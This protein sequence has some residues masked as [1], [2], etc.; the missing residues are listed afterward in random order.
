MSRSYDDKGRLAYI[1]CDSCDA[2]IRPSSGIDSSEW[3]KTGTGNP[4]YGTYQQDWCP[5]CWDKRQKT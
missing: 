5:G 4:I 2:K 3:M 1:E